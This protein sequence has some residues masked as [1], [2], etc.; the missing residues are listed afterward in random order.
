M[1]F[2][3][4]IILIGLLG[5]FDISASEN[6]G[7]RLVLLGKAHQML[8]DRSGP[9]LAIIV[10]KLDFGPELLDKRKIIYTR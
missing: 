6:H 9:S 3:L 10:K 2:F 4:S 8:T 7:T 5:I 1:R